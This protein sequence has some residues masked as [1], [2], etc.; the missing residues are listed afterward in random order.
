MDIIA[1]NKDLALVIFTKCNKCNKEISR[2]PKKDL[3]NLVGF[4]LTRRIGKDMC[5]VCKN[6]ILSDIH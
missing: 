4:T 1:E 3:I 2:T 6:E 5:E